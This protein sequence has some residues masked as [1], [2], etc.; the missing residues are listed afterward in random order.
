LKPPQAIDTSR[1]RLRPP[2]ES[3]IDAIFEYASDAAVTELMDWRRLT[4]RD[5]VA[6]FLART[7]EGW[8]SGAEFTWVIT[9]REA[10]FVIGATSIRV[11]GADADFGYVLNRRYWGRGIAVEAASP[12]VSWATSVLATPRLWATCDTE[13]HRSARVLEKLG[14][15]REGLGQGIVRPNISDEPRTSFVYARTGDG[16]IGDD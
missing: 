12:I 7:A 13:N 4:G 14:L 5:E 6:D 16:T 15:V 9:E 2:V 10:S 1:L 8:R 3:D 11:R